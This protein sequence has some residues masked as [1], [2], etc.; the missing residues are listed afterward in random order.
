MKYILILS[1]IFCSLQDSVAQNRTYKDSVDLILKLTKRGNRIYHEKNFEG[2]RHYYYNKIQKQ[3]VSV[4]Y[5][6]RKKHSAYEYHFINRQLV[7]MRLYLP[8]SMSPESIGKQMA[9][10]YYFCNDKLADKIEINFPIIDIDYYKVLGLEL[11]DRA[12]KFLNLQ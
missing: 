9:A 1:L 2:T 7:K 3:I 11:F 5:V 4:I 6:P 8:Y 12:E 10:A